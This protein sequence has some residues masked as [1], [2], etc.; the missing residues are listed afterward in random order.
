MAGD[1]VGGYDHTLKKFA[2]GVV[3]GTKKSIKKGLVAMYAAGTLIA[4]PTLEHSVWTENHRDYVAAQN[5]KVGDTF[6]DGKGATLRLDSLVVKPD[7][8]L[9][10]Y[11]FEVENLHN[12]YVGTQEVLVHNECVTLELLEGKLG[13]GAREQ[14][15]AFENALKKSKISPADRTKFYNRILADLNSNKLTEVDAKRLM[16]EFSSTSLDPKIKTFLA[17]FI[18]KGSLDV[19]KAT[20]SWG[21]RLDVL[22][23]M[24]NV[25]INTGKLVPAYSFF[26]TTN[27]FEVWQGTV[28][29]GTRWATVTQTKVIAK[30]GGTTGRLQNDFNQVL[31]VYPTMKK[32]EY[33]VDG[34]F[35]Y[36]TDANGNVSQMTD[37]NVEYFDKHVRTERHE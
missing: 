3:K 1:E 32:M 17:N 35:V 15:T 14:I 23:Q 19:W 8:T 30:A 22:A 26:E 36:T 18:D 10:V 16:T 29:S 25:K 37:K 5:L 34:R 13:T 33:E 11:N 21:N 7:T 9:T 27:G 31:N 24:S 6:L 4:Q 28:P 12:Y 20:K 2:W